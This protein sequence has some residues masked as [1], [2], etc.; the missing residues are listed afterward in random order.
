MAQIL[1]ELNI[2]DK[3]LRVLQGD[4]TEAQ[5]DAIVNAANS[6]LQHG[7][8]VAGAIVRAG[9]RQIQ[10]ESDK[11]GFVPEGEV[12]VTGAGALAAK[13]VI[14]A[15]G[16]RGG[17][18]QAD[19]KLTNA[20]QNSLNK[21][22]ELGLASVSM[23][24]I[25]SGIFGFPKDRC[26]QVL[27]TTAH[28]WLQAHP[29]SSVVQVDMMNLDDETAGIFAETFD[30]LFAALDGSVV[31]SGAPEG[32]GDVT[33]FEVAPG[34]EAVLDGRSDAAT[35]EQVRSWLIGK[36]V[37]EPAAATVA[38]AV[39][40]YSRHESAQPFLHDAQGLVDAGRGEELS[41]QQLLD[42]LF[43]QHRAARFTAPFAI[44]VTSPDAKRVVALDHEQEYQ[45]KYD[46]IMSA[47]RQ[48]IVRRRK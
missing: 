32:A 43:L 30:D 47:L 36:D 45:H 27:L 34:D 15:V 48:R 2:A 44:A 42:L 8:G 11:T 21:A 7:G 35:I 25:S 22:D 16:P 40:G 13:Y 1:R 28:D 23:P 6:H 5:T 19:E 24:A 37:E 38:Y 18:P 4:L 20:V 10:D 14:H 3:V 17:D 46:R 12:A 29:D 9:G 39:N 26:A 33:V 41:T 31:T